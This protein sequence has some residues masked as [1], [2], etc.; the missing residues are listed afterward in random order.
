[1]LINKFFRRGSALLLTAAVL[2]SIFSLIYIPASAIDPTGVDLDGAQAMYLYNIENDK[3][4]YEKN[5]YEKIHP[6]S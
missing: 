2:I 5:I 1:M 6:V 3:V 4:L